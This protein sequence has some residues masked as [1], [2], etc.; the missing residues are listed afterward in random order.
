MDIYIGKF[1][2]LIE[3]INIMPVIHQ[4][5]SQRLIPLYGKRGVH[6]ALS[7]S[8]RSLAIGN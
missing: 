6:K 7:D 2:L 1:G 5:Q 4:N 3:N 8:Y